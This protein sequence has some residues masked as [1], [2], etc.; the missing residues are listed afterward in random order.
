MKILVTGATG[1]LGSH[2]VDRLL[3]QEHEVHV[4]TRKTSSLRWLKN[5]PVVFHEGDVAGDLENIKRAVAGMDIVFHLAGVIQAL[6]EEVYFKANAFGTKQILEACLLYKNIQRV[7]VVTSL[8]A[9]GPGRDHITCARES[10]TS[11]P[12]NPYGASKREAEKIAL[13][14][15][16]RLPITII[17]PPAIYGPRDEQFLSLFRMIQSG[18]V[19]LPGLRKKFI[20][21]SFVEDIVS[22]LVL[23]AHHPAA[24]GEI[25]FMGDEKNYSWEEAA[26]I[27]SKVM[28]KNI[29]MI[30]LP[31]P[32]VYSAACIADFISHV[33]GRLLPLNWDNVTNFIQKNWMMDISKAKTMLGYK[34]QFSLQ[35]GIE[36][37]YHYLLET[38]FFKN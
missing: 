26:H 9:H 31:S 2:L 6:Q 13:S 37:T 12:V 35:Q 27:F 7:V 30:S 21:A 8:A 22:G 32:L 36:K 3:T 23:A 20:N 19:F 16:Q 11:Y 24:V 28:K 34:P 15:S 1:F 25:F 33:T 14:Y 18:F 4:L 5:K 10:D 29:V 17:R 38:G